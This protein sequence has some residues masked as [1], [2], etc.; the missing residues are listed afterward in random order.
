MEGGGEHDGEGSP[1]GNSP[2]HAFK[3][4]LA[5]VFGNLTFHL[6]GGQGH[7]QCGGHIVLDRGRNG[8]LFG[9]CAHPDVGRIQ[10][11]KFAGTDLRDLDPGDQ[12]QNDIRRKPLFQM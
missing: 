12:R 11:F 5:D 6:S 4:F 2:Y 8:R 7:G 10:M 1:E 9:G 3:L